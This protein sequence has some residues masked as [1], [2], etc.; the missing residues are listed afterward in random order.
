MCKILR[1]I[2]QSKTSLQS[3]ET[4]LHY[5]LNMQK[6]YSKEWEYACFMQM[7]SNRLAFYSA[8]L[9]S[10]PCKTKFAIEENVFMTR[11]QATEGATANGLP[12]MLSLE[13]MMMAET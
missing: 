8:F 3:E 9:P 2:F 12:C 6:Q 1:V 10:L 11:Q 5:A 7:V 4:P 13:F